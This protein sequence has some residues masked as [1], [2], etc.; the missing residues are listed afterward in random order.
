MLK[1][2]LECCCSKSKDVVTYYILDM[3]TAMTGA[4]VADKIGMYT[5]TVEIYIYMHSG[6]DLGYSS[7]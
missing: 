2:N 7:R 5:S 6:S 1:D 3:S 4:A